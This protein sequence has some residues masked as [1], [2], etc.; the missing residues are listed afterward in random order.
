MSKKELESSSESKVTPKNKL[1]RRRPIVNNVVNHVEH[2]DNK[3]ETVGRLPVK[4]RDKKKDSKMVRFGKWT[5]DEFERYDDAIEKYGPDWN[6]IASEV[7]TR[8]NE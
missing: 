3:I 7:G 8:N 4:K 6:K 1:R 5:D 2:I